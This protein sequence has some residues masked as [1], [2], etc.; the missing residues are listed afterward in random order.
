MG[1]NLS[2]TFEPDLSGV[3]LDPG[4]RRDD[5]IMAVIWACSLYG[6]GV[7][8]GTLA[9]V[10]RWM[11]VLTNKRR[12]TTFGS[13]LAAAFMALAWPVVAAYL[14]YSPS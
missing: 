9:L 10:D 5:I 2:S 13:V 14:M 8:W 1:N 7:I 6:V 3:V 12:P 11:G 4:D